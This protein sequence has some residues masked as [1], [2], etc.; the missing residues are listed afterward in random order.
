MKPASFLTSSKNHTVETTHA[1]SAAK[2]VVSPKRRLRF[3]RHACGAERRIVMK[4]QR[5][6]AAGLCTLL[7]FS[8]GIAEA[9]VVLDWNEIMVAV[10]ADQPP[11]DMNRFAAI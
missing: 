4:T 1:G 2:W 8:P 9:D 10:V 6:A 3:I 7:M 5:S 11:P